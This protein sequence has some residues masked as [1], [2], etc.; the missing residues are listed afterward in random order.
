MLIY[1]YNVYVYL[2]V[3]HKYIHISYIHIG[4]DASIGVLVVGHAGAHEAPG[5]PGFKNFRSFP[6]IKGKFWVPLGGYLAVVSP[7]IAPYCPIQPLSNTCLGGICWYISGVLS[8]GYPTFPF[9]LNPGWFIGI[10]NTMACEIIVP[11]KLE[12]FIL[13]SLTQPTRGPFLI[14]QMDD[15]TIAVTVAFYPY[16]RNSEGPSEQK[17]TQV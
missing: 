16:I 13:S 12:D 3:G 5:Q 10:L 7:R 15:S 14:A 1:T 9:E 2:Y 11:I 17:K 6:L 8:Q 4:M